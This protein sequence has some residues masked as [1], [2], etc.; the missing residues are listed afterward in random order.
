VPKVEKELE[1]LMKEINE[2]HNKLRS[3]NRQAREIDMLIGNLED[4]K[5]KIKNAGDCADII[6]EKLM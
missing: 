5:L 4:I 6:A 1:G 2:K 3:V